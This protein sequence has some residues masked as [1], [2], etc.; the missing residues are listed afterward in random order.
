MFWLLVLFI[1]EII[2]FLVAFIFSGLDIMAPSVMMCVMFALST[3]FALAYAN[4]WNIDYSA[5]A[6]LLLAS[7]I[8]VFFLAE[9]LFRFIFYS[10]LEGAKLRNETAHEIPRI[11]IRTWKT[12]LCFLLCVITI[13]WYFKIIKRAVGSAPSIAV[14][15]VMYRKMGIAAMAGEGTKDSVGLLKPFLQ[16]LTALGY[17]ASY[18]FASALFTKKSKKIE[19]IKY[20]ALIIL[21]LAPSIMTGGR[22]GMLRVGSALIIEYYILWH[23]KYGWNKNLSWK[24]IRLGV[25]GFIVLVLVFYYSLG[26]LGRGTQKSIIDYA[27]AYLGSSIE[28]FNQYVKS[29]VPCEAFGEESLFSLKKLMHFLHIGK[30]S[31]HYNLEFRNLGTGNSNVYTFFRRPLHDFG[32]F[33][34]Y[35]FTILVSFFFSWI[36]H[37]KIKYRTREK[38]IFW[39]L[40]YGYLY[41][42]LVCSS[43]VQFSITYI[44]AG[45]VIAMVFIYVGYNFLTRN[46]GKYGKIFTFKC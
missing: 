18:F 26:L 34:M 9:V 8:L 3:G 12:T 30:I 38:S 45:T 23:Q 25:F 17:I 22:T 24:Y 42:W 40:L 35:A 20:I 16:I 29:P 5:D 36:Y 33:G 37:G 2:L 1:C 10:R 4:A 43:I 44:S 28:L 27:A 39:T 46:L 19:K 15:F 6:C 21:S 7:G 32:I 31:T 14:Y 11:Y 13:L 41:Y